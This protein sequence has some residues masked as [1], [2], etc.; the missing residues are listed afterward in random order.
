MLKDGPAGRHFAFHRGNKPGF[1]A[2]MVRVL[3]DRLTVIVLSNRTEG[4]SSRLA[5]DVGGILFRKLLPSDPRIDRIQAGMGRGWMRASSNTVRTAQI[6]E[7][8]PRMATSPD[9]GLGS[10]SPPE[11]GT[12]S[13]ACPTAPGTGAIQPRAPLDR[14]ISTHRSP[15]DN[16]RTGPIRR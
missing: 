2:T 10:G 4:D 1:S 5:N 13:V 9:D 14:P 12:G 11:R 7:S 6:S 16:I 8:H 3:E 15:T